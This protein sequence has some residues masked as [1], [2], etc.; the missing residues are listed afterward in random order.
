M[1]SYDNYMKEAVSQVINIYGPDAIGHKLEEFKTFFEDYT[2]IA[3]I[4]GRQSVFSSASDTPTQNLQQALIASGI[5]KEG[6]LPIGK[7][8]YTIKLEDDDLQDTIEQKLTH[9]LEDLEAKMRGGKGYY[10][11]NRYISENPHS[12]PNAYEMVDVLTT[13]H[14]LV[15]CGK[16]PSNDLKQDIDAMF[17]KRK[18]NFIEN[19]I[20]TDSAAY[21]ICEFC[22]NS[23]NLGKGPIPEVT[24]AAM[25]KIASLD[26][27][28]RQQER[29]HGVPFDNVAEVEGV[30]NY[31]HASENLQPGFLDRFQEDLERIY[32]MAKE[33]KEKNKAREYE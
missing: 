27:Y 24:I 19:G 13:Y 2:M 9:K 22:Q 20:G 12:D 28:T 15:A 23:G 6:K 11:I 30:R 31:F 10:G 16:Q 8:F 14:N 25:R 21:R 1:L 4:K 32:T 7:C 29:D 17:Q 5:Q 33:N 3:S 18:Q 26:L